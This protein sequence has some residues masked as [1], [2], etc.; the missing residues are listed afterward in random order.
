MVGE[1]PPLPPGVVAIMKSTMLSSKQLRVHRTHV[2][3][4]CGG[5]WL[6]SKT[7]N[8]E[9]GYATS[10]IR[11]CFIDN[12][13][14]V[15]QFA[16]CRMAWRVQALAATWKCCCAATGEGGIISICCCWVRCNCISLFS[17]RRFIRQVCILVDLY[18]FD[19]T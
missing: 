9:Q 8:A 2:P 12:R 18:S 13:S 15:E 3:L 11:G 19:N 6:T 16:C 5:D 7:A 17:C 10:C 1:G 14:L 4:P